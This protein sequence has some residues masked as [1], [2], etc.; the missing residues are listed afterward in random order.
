M[1][2]NELI[3][4]WKKDTRIDD[5]NLDSES[6]KVPSLHSKYMGHLSE[7]RME[8]RQLRIQRRLLV[9]DLF[10][11]YH[12]DL[13]NPEDLERISREPYVKKLMKNDV[14]S[15]VEADREVMRMDAKMEMQSEL[16]DTL[17]EI[18]KSINNRGYSL[19][20]AIDWRRLTTGG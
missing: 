11:Y 9:K 19:K 1:K 6:L 4:E 12:G 16:V 15:Y 18:M 10:E 2:I 7:S 13:N 3:D 5:L 17:L 8:L 20:N 14:M